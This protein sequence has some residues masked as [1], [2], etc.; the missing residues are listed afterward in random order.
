MLLARPVL[1]AALACLAA[2]GC[3]PQ[4]DRIARASQRAQPHLESYQRFERWAQRALA[5]PSATLQADALGE[6]VFAPIRNTPGVMGAWVQIAG[7]RP[8][9][10]ALP[11]SSPLPRDASWV[12]LRAPPFGALRVADAER[13]PVAR[14]AS[15]AAPA[16]ACVLVTRTERDAVARALTVTMAFASDPP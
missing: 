3:R 15:Q 9:T 4:V 1:L 8:L 6:I 10:L 13:C 11:A 7:D 16:P 5:A 2:L 14:V 12:A